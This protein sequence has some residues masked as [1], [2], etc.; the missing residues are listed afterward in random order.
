MNQMLIWKKDCRGIPGNDPVAVITI[1]TASAVVDFWIN[2]LS[3]NPYKFEIEINNVFTFTEMA[4]ANLH[5]SIGAMLLSYEKIH[6]SFE[7]EH[8]IMSLI[9]VL[10]GFSFAEER[11]EKQKIKKEEEQKEDDFEIML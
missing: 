1:N 8:V 3:D 4:A 5:Q 10:Q 2:C 11:I 7:S 6:G 9:A